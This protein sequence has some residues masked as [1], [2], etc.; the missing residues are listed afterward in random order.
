MR[1]NTLCAS[2]LGLVVLCASPAQASGFGFSFGKHSR[3]GSFGVFW[4]PDPA[5]ICPP[6]AV[7]VPGCYESVGEQVWVPGSCE[8]VWSPPIFETRYDCYG[9]PYQICRAPGHW[10]TVERPG[11]YETRTVR[12]WRPAHWQTPA[13]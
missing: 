4:S 3:H 10:Q 13:Y 12:V 8:R 2:L 9:R 5:P 11:H 7:W 6:R 1:I